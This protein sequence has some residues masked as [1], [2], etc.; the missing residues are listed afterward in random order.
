MQYHVLS[1]ASSCNLRVHIVAL[2]EN[3]LPTALSENRNVFLHR[4]FP[5]RTPRPSHKI[6]G[7]L[8]YLIGAI[9]KLFW[10]FLQILWILVFTVP[11]GLHSV[12]VQNPPA[13]PV[14]AATWLSCFLRRASFVI[15]WHNLGFSMVSTALGFPQQL[16]P[17]SPQVPIPS[18]PIRLITQLA[19]LYEQI[20]GKRATLNITVSSAMAEYL[21]SEGFVRPGSRVIVLYDRPPSSFMPQ[22]EE[23]SGAIPFDE[24]NSEWVTRVRNTLRLSPGTLSSLSRFER[25]RNVEDPQVMLISGTSWTQDEDFGIL[26]E[27][28]KMY[29]ARA[30]ALDSPLPRVV[31]IV[32]GKG[33]LQQAYETQISLLNLQRVSIHTGFLSRE[34]YPRLLASADIGVCLHTS[35]SGL[36]L[37][38]KIVDLFGCGVPVIAFNYSTIVELVSTIDPSIQAQLKPPT[39]LLFTTQETLFAHLLSIFS[40]TGLQPGGTIDQMRTGVLQWRSLT[41]EHNWDT[42]LKAFFSAQQ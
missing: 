12:V 42:N 15:D 29:D 23:P 40:K 33:P 31:C 20:F 41:W 28:L 39:G 32:T 26:L 24:R 27:A 16:D 7:R 37:P 19:K 9:L 18:T 14:L 30:A 25:G 6:V 3:D 36:D 35:T 8:L 1:L 13:I 10:F 21:R 34:D 5:L 2:L 22:T 17:H 38:M 4:L 11:S